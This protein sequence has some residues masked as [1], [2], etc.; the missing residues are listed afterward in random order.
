MK[1]AARRV[2]VL[3]ALVLAGCSSADDGVPAPGA[4]IPPVR[5]GQPAPKVTVDPGVLPHGYFDYPAVSPGW[6]S[7]PQVADDVFVGLGPQDESG[8]SAVVAVDSHGTVLWRAEVPHGAVVDTS[9]AGEKDLVV[10]TVPAGADGW[11]ASAFDLRSGEPEWERVALPGPPA[12]PGLLVDGPDGRVAIDPGS[13]KLLPREEGTVVL[14]EDLGTVITWF[15]DHLQA[16][17]DGQPVWS[18]TPQ[19]LGLPATARLGVVTGSMTPAGTLAVGPE[20]D[21]HAASTGT[22]VDLTDGSALATDV[23][24]AQHDAVLGTLVTLGGG[25]LSSID[26]GAAEWS[27][28]VPDGA[29]LVAADGALAYLRVAEEV[30]VVN[31]A[32]GADAYVYDEP[33]PQGLAVPAA[34]SSSGAIALNTGT[35]VLLPTHRH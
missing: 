21:A 18:V 4:L 6:A 5:S 26:N 14:A 23:R 8:S 32:T 1:R 15:S 19:D 11:A 31:T 29:R 13:G 3:V 10:M 35:W 7:A 2:V 12:G 33:G 9:R 28:E 24:D 22:L 27:R 16:H 25:T 20:T 34:V 17:R 30:L